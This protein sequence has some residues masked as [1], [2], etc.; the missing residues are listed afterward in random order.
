ALIA[1]GV[2]FYGVWAPPAT[3]TAP[4]RGPARPADGA[5]PAAAPPAPPAQPPTAYSPIATNHLFNPLRTQ[6]AAA[7]TGPAR[8]DEPAVPKGPPPPRP[9]LYGV[10]L[11]GELPRAFLED[12]RTKK[13]SGYQIGDSV[14]GSKLEEIK[15]DR[16]VM[17]GDGESFE[18]LLRDPSKPR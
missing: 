17:R 4:D 7:P 13:I 15:A 16:V 11:G 8:P 14:A 5:G 2:R 3:P 9:R 10:I 18:V 12:P 1:L 6:A